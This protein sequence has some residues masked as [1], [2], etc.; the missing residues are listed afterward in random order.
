MVDCSFC[1]KYLPPNTVCK[2]F[3][4]LEPPVKILPNDDVKTIIAK[5]KKMSPRRRKRMKEI[6]HNRIRR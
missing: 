4:I 2:C 6:I 3:V 5:I 1:G